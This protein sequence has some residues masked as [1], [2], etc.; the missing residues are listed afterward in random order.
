MTIKVYH[1]GSLV[2]PSQIVVKGNSGTLRGV[3]FVLGKGANTFHTVWEGIYTTD[4]STT[5][6]FNTND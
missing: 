5:T 3:N 1:S 6:T 4:R 2:E